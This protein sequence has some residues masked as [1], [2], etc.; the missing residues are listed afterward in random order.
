MTQV[1]LNP[2]ELDL[3]I[4]SLKR[5]RQIISD[6]NRSAKQSLP[7]LIEDMPYKIQYLIEKLEPIFDEASEEEE[8]EKKI[9]K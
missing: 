3:I 9:K 7:Q 2:S 4:S 8:K 5:N 6:L 1:E